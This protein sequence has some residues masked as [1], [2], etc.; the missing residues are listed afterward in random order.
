MANLRN[1]RSLPGPS[2]TLHR[3][4]I[5]WSSEQKSRSHLGY[6]ESSMRLSLENDAI[7]LVLLWWRFKSCHNSLRTRTGQWDLFWSHINENMLTSSK[8]SFSL[9]CVKALHSTYLTAPSSFA[10]RSPSS[11]LTGVIFCF[12]SF[13]RTL[14]SSLRSVCVPTMRQGT[15]GQ[16]WWTSGNHFS[17]TFSNDAG[18]VTEKQTRK[19]SV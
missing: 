4:P 15:P 14:G 12:A 16:W 13:S 1:R 18:D 10:I 11:F 7:L 6:P 9:Y 3:C 2:S 8:T 17:R 19:T 5:E